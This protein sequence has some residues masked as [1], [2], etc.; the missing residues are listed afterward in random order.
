MLDNNLLEKSS[1][2]S[3]LSDFIRKEIRTENFFIEKNPKNNF[4]YMK[5]CNEKYYNI[6]SIDTNDMV[7]KFAKRLIGKNF[8]SILISGLGLGILPYLCQNTT[9]VVDV[10]ELESEV[11]D[12]VNQIEHLKS[13]VKIINS[14]IWDFTT[15]SRYDVILFDHWMS[16]ATQNEIENLKNKFQQNLNEGGIIT[17][18]IYEQSVR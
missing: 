12:I 11:I 14:S 2:E 16:Y 7:K 5:N 9:E 10:I 15:D 6:L 18:P 3:L 17:I 13:N 1:Q 8:N 4:W